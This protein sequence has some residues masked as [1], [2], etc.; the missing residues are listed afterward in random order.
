MG[1][2]LVNGSS[3]VNASGGGVL[4]KEMLGMP[5]WIWL[6][7]VLAIIVVA[8]IIAV[9]CINKS[10]KNNEAIGNNETTKNNDAQPTDDVQKHEK[11]APA[12]TVKA[13]EEK[14]VKQAEEEKPAEKKPAAKTTATKTTAKTSAAKT[15]AKTEESNSEPKVYHISK[16]KEDKKWQVKAEGADKA[17]RLFF[18]QADAIEYAKKVAGNQE[19]RI[20]IHK[21]GGGFRKL[22][23]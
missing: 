8:V 23:Y 21:E 16:R 1:I 5:L 14:P 2:H 17:L 4:A 13:V 3:G 12:A 10:S 22:N 20:V 18:T 11:A 7:I 15:S 6:V 9:V 19:G